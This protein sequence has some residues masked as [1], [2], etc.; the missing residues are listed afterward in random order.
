MAAMQAADVG[1][2]AP[3]T[4]RVASIVFLEPWRDRKLGQLRTWGMMSSGSSGSAKRGSRWISASFDRTM[5][6]LGCCSSHSEGCL[7]GPALRVGLARPSSTSFLLRTHGRGLPGNLPPGPVRCFSQCFG[8]LRPGRIWVLEP[9]GSSRRLRGPCGS[10][11]VEG[12]GVA[13]GV[14]DQADQLAPVA[15]SWWCP[16]GL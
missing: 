6:S 14:I 1:T 5:T 7:C 9:H 4:I 15:L 10:W 2:L 3:A 11:C 12:G 16:S 13:T 8:V